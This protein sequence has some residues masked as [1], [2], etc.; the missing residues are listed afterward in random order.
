MLYTRLTRKDP[1]NLPNG[2]LLE[3]LLTFLL[4][5]HPELNNCQ[6]ASKVYKDS[7]HST[8]HGGPEKEED[9]LSL[10]IQTAEPRLTSIK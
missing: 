6:N 7:Q 4:L 8:Y 1:V 10:L 5:R 9:F 2:K 3:R